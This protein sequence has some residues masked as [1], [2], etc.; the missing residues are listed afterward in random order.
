MLLQT[1]YRERLLT[2]YTEVKKRLDYQLAT[3]QFLRRMEQDHMINWV[4]QNVRK[5]ITA[6]QVNTKWLLSCMS[7]YN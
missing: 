4:E 6:Q 1:N 5:S 2:V 7:S 3:Q